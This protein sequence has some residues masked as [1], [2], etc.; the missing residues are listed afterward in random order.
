MEYVLGIDFGT[1]S[2]RALVVDA[3]SGKELALGVAYYPR[4]SKEMYCDPIA[5]K[6]RQH[7]MDYV[8]SLVLAVS[9]AVEKLS[10][11]Q[12]KSIKGIC[13]DTTGSTP[14]LIDSEGVPLALL[15]EFSEEPDAMFVLWKDHTSIS[16]AEEINSLADGWDVDFTSY[17][18]GVYSSEWVWAKV[19]HI[20]RTNDKVRRAAYAW[21]EHCDWISSLLAGNTKSENVLR[22]RCVAGHKAMWNANWDG[23]PSAEFLG[24]LHPDLALMRPRLYS[25]TYT[26]DKCAGTLSAEWAVKLGLIEGI[27]ISVGLLDAHA[28]AVGAQVEPGVLVRIIGTSTCDIMVS[29]YEVIGDRLIAGISGQVDGSVI[30]GYVG[31][32]AGQ[33]AF[34]DIY[35]W[36]KDFLSWSLLKYMPEGSER[37][38]ALDSIL[39][40]LTVEA[41][42]I[43]VSRGN[44]M[45]LDWMNGRRT[46]FADQTLKGAISELSLGSTPSA[47]YRALVEATAF[48][49]RAIVDHFVEMGLDITFINAI[50]GISKKSPFVMQVMSDVLNRPIRVV[51]SEQVCALGSA[52]FA[53]VVAGIHPNVIK[54]G[55]VMGAGYEKEYVPNA[56]NVEAYQC[57]Y[58]KYLQKGILAEKF[59]KNSGN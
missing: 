46:P 17:S 58:D 57:L 3:L 54:A 21:I 47:V 5:N 22:S 51:K 34:G 20:L 49:S 19:L 28:G 7:P 27:P 59:S 4:W 42:A 32:E 14:V 12:A 26:S 38:A 24:K 15:E 6:Y 55:Q 48:G 16:E 2:C 1:D 31:F 45:A 33:S 52:M 13:I 8:E 25:S 10:E 41:E 18:G 37:D 40:D 53:S 39:K 36:F 35:A 9:K 29:P 43:P 23:L 50:G 11:D 30:P 56:R 44:V